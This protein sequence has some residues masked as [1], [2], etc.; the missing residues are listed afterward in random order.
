MTWLDV[1]LI[2]LT[3]AAIVSRSMAIKGVVRELKR[4][5]APEA[6]V[7]VARRDMEL[8]PTPPPGSDDIVTS[9]G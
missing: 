4:L 5:G 8:V 6:L 2:Y 9:R 7:A 3:A 1:K